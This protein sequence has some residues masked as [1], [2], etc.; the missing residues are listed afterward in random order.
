MEA[1]LNRESTTTEP[2]STA[3]AAIKPMAAPSALSTM[4]YSET[5]QML[6][7]IAQPITAYA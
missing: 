4:R 2:I 3:P 5:G 6:S 1:R 7:K